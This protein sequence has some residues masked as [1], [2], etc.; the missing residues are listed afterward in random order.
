MRTDIAQRR[1]AKQCVRDSVGQ[2]VAVRV[3]RGTFFKRD[4]HSSQDQ[5]A[6]RHQG[7]DIVSEAGPDERSKVERRR[8]KV[9]R[10]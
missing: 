7:M 9:D 10:R 3:P 6:A 5:F 4:S 2:R 8:S 1:G